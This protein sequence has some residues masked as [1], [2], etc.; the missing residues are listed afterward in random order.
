M[1]IQIP[2]SDLLFREHNCLYILVFGQFVYETSKRAGLLDGIM[3]HCDR[4]AQRI[5][6][7]LEDM[8]ASSVLSR[9]FSR[10][11]STVIIPLCG[12]SEADSLVQLFDN[13][14]SHA[15]PYPLAPLLTPVLFTLISHTLLDGLDKTKWICYVHKRLKVKC[16]AK[17]FK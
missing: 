1:K 2:E 15:P 13:V 11:F 12:G 3:E 4:L 9:M 10:S 7:Q 6:A 16:M 8:R 5:A 14:R 17:F